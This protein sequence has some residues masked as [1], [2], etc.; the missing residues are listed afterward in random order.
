M[1]GFTHLAG[2]IA[3]IGLAMHVPAM[4]WATRGAALGATI[5]P[6]HLFFGN[7]VYALIILT[8]R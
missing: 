5:K 8:T 3:L 7:T 4:T 2:A 1:L 6:Q